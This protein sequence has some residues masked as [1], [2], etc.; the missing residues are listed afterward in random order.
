MVAMGDDGKPAKVPPLQLANADERHRFAA[1]RLRKQLRQE[2][3][4]RLSGNQVFAAGGISG[5][6]AG[7]NG[8]IGRRPPNQQLIL[9]FESICQAHIR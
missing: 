9:I 7:S 5:Q 1:A 2:S 6:G 3:E 4:Q 8:G